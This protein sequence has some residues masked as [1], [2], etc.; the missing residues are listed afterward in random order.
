MTKLRRQK[1]KPQG[2]AAGGAPG[3][4]WRVTEAVWGGVQRVR[5]TTGGPEIIADPGRVRSVHAVGFVGPGEVLL[6][7]N[8]DGT[9]TFPGGRLEDLETPEEALSRE[10]W[11]EAR[12][13]L[14]PGYVPIAATQVE[15]LNQ[16][17]G[18]VRRFHP[19]FLLWYAGAVADLS[20]EPHHDPADYVTGRR[21]TSVDEAR[22]LLAPIENDVLTAALAA[23]P[24]ADGD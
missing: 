4:A 15:F 7:Q 16:V 23:W 18:R 17:P 9:W 10:I 1:G 5:L 22:A 3:S 8:K 24:R 13:T 21:I 2:A 6:V 12:A 11:E 14:A 20:D 19:T